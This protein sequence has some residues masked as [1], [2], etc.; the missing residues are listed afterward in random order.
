MAKSKTVKENPD[1]ISAA[2]MKSVPSM[3]MLSALDL[4][5][6]HVVADYFGVE[7]QDTIEEQVLALSEHGVTYAL[8]AKEFKIPLPDDYV[9]EEDEP[10]NELDV[11]EASEVNNEP[12]TVERSASLAPQQ[13]Y[14]IKMTRANPYF[15]VA[16]VVSKGKVFRFTQE[17][18]YAIMDARTA[19]YVLERETGFRQAFP[20]E[21]AEFY[22]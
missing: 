18:P 11:E 8:Y 14:L 6:L 15:E 7:S 22:E 4:P 5:T 2:D 19:Q 17:H 10:L 21:L 3:N 9:E 12:V 1:A 13:E 20:D 16:S